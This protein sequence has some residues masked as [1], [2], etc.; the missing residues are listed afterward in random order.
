VE[1]KYI[2]VIALILISPLRGNQLQDLKKEKNKKQNAMLTSIAQ[3]ITRYG[4]HFP[5]N[6]ELR[7]IRMLDMG[8]GL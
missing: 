2:A 5:G 4:K 3:A 7:L 6:L 8:F 1:V